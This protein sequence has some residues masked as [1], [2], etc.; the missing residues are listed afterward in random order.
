ME[1]QNKGEVDMAQVEET[2]LVDEKQGNM[3]IR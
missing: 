3:G 2:V 1:P